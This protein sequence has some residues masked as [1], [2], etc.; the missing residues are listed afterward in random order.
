LAAGPGERLLDDV[1]N[2]QIV[3]HEQ[4]GLA[5]IVHLGFQTGL[6][7]QQFDPRRVQT[8]EAAPIAVDGDPMQDQGLVGGIEVEGDLRQLLDARGVGDLA[9]EVQVAL[10]SLRI[11]WRKAA[12][13][14]DSHLPVDQQ[15]GDAAPR[16]GRHDGTS[17]WHRGGIDPAGSGT[18]NDA[19]GGRETAHRARWRCSQIPTPKAK[20]QQQERKHA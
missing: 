7:T 13:A 1:A 14:I 9:H 6:A 11:R 17:G 8:L 5:A 18:D 15:H 19:G 2:P 20:A 16:L 12:G 10:D 4:R 3:E